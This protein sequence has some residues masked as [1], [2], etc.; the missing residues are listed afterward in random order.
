MS[1]HARF[2]E[3][4]VEAVRAV[5]QLFSATPTVEPY[6]PDGSEVYR[7]QLAGPA[8]GVE[9]LLWPS[10]SRVD[11]KSTGNHGWVL[12]GVGV[13]EVIEGTEVIFRPGSGTGFLF[14]S[15]NGRVNMVI[16]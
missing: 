14:I 4:T 7:L 1:G 5:G 6:S 3:L 15:I 10:L 2:E 11:V 9:I 16:G 12:R 8:D 13:V